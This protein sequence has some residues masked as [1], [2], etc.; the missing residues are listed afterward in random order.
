MFFEVR[1]RIGRLV[2][3][4]H[5]LLHGQTDVGKSEDTVVS[6][7]NLNIFTVILPTCTDSLAS[8]G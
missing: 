7:E 4:A 2:R 1:V 5:Q 8:F 6:S 3:V